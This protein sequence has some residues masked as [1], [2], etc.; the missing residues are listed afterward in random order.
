MSGQ[1]LTGEETGQSNNIAVS[2]R[3]TDTKGNPVDV[4]RLQQ[5]PI[6][7]AE[8]TIRRSS[9]LKFPFNELALAQ[10]FPSGWEILNTRMSVA[11]A[12]GSSPAEYQDARDDR[13]YTYFDLPFSWDHQNNRARE[14]VSTYR[15]QL[16]AAYAGRY[17]LPAVSCEAM[18]DSR[19]RASVP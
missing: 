8:V 14:T 2:V 1:S 6:F 10:I 11:T 18:Y 7:V 4:G 5:A 13:V 16:N 15:V 17:Y 12:R 9:D 3:Y 19:I